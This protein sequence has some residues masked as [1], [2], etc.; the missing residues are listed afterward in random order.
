MSLIHRRT[1]TDGPDGRTTDGR[2]RISGTGTGC[3]RSCCTWSRAA[4][5][6]AARAPRLRVQKRTGAGL[7][8]AAALAPTTVPVAVATAMVVTKMVIT[9]RRSCR[10]DEGHDRD[11]GRDRVGRDARGRAVRR[12]ARPSAHGRQQVGNAQRAGQAGAPGQGPRWLAARRERAC[13]TRRRALVGLLAAGLALA[14]SARAQLASVSEVVMPAS[15]DIRS[16]WC[17]KR[18]LGSSEGVARGGPA[19][20]GA[21][22]AGRAGRRHLVRSALREFKLTNGR[23]PRHFR[24][25]RAV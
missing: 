25:A 4:H 2:T 22:A 10:A 17:M 15:E 11:A 19:G 5:G 7:A 16:Q 6:P 13:F 1:E 3:T 8:P 14:T 9:R 20:A 23:R 12:P 18:R 24:G 21:A